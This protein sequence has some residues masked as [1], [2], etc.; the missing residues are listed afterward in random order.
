MFRYAVLSTSNMDTISLSVKFEIN[1]SEQARFVQ[2]C[3]KS[4][5]RRIGCS[6][7]GGR[8]ARRP[9]WARTC[10]G[11]VLQS[12]GVNQCSAAINLIRVSGCGAINPAHYH[13][14]V[15]LS[16]RQGFEIFSHFTDH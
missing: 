11:N 5:R 4:R 8:A 10:Y 16:I 14:T 2:K 13:A 6:V 15:Y 7:M 3:D 12:F 1:R 9:R